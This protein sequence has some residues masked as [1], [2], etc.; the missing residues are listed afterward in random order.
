[1]FEGRPKLT[2]WRDRVKKEVGEKL[3][4][5]THEQIMNVRNL[6]KSIQKDDRLEL[7]KARFL[8]IFT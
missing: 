1:M 5:E 4:D 2:A 3:F 8:R 7:L 6:V